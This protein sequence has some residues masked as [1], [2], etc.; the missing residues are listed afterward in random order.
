[1]VKGEAVRA[2]TPSVDTLK[3]TRKP[4]G[5]K[6]DFPVGR[7]DYPLGKRRRKIEMD[8]TFYQN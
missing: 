5:C 1:M 7:F 6:G 3:M 4:Q 8:A 2:A